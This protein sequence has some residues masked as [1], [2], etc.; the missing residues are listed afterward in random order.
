MFKKTY[1]KLIPIL[2]ATL[3]LILVPSTSIA[4]DSEERDLLQAIGDNTDGLEGVL[5]TIDVD[6]GSMDTLLGT[7]DTDTGNIATSV[8]TIAG[9]TTSLDEKILIGE[10]TST[11]LED[12]DGAIKGS[13]GWLGG[14]LIVTNGTDNATL[15]IYNDV[16]SADGTALAKWVVAGGD[17]DGGVMFPFP[18]EATVG[19][20]A[21]IEGTG[22]NY[23]V[24]YK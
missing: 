10:L 2:I 15:I 9:D 4:I 11:G 18:V 13:A 17:L 6:T 12:S 16:D 19:M 20:Y 21:D 22:A 8:S 14:F 3:L 1:L 7:I 24:Y 5:T 23:W